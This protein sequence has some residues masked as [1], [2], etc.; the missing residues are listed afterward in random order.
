MYTAPFNP[1]SLP[2]TRHLAEYVD[3][4]LIGIVFLLKTLLPCLSR[5]GGATYIDLKSD[6]NTLALPRPHSLP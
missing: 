1:S 2:L 6:W 5:L 4:N 3:E